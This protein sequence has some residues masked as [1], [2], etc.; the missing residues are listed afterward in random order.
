MGRNEWQCRYFGGDLRLDAGIVDH[1][2]VYVEVCGVILLDHCCG[3]VWAVHPSIRF[4]RNIDFSVLQIEEVHKVLPE[5]EELGGDIELISSVCSAL[6]EARAHGLI[7]EDHVGEVGPRPGVWNGPVSSRL[8]K[9]R[10][11]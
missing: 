1:H 8:P 2:T 10:R 4:S 3:D 6:R 7:D 11:V 9:K 5:G